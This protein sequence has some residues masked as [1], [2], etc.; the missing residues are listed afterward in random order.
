MEFL[1]A[2]PVGMSLA[3]LK[4]ETAETAC[5]Q[6]FADPGQRYRGIVPDFRAE[7]TFALNEINDLEI[8]RGHC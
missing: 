1:V 4:K 8:K 6:P 3:S 5:F 2:L 7:L